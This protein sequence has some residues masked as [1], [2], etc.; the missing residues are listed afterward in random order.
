MAAAGR[1]RCHLEEVLRRVRVDRREPGREQ[2]LRIRVVC[3]AAARRYE[4]PRSVTVAA[5][6]GTCRDDDADRAHRPC[7]DEAG[8]ALVGGAR[9]QAVEE[10]A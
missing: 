4:K 3:V 10:A 2:K 9:E 1:L 5:E 8:Y 6:L 7:L